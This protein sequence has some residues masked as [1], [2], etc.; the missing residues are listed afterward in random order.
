M[1]D[2]T[3]VKDIG[4]FRWGEV[5]QPLPWPLILLNRKTNSEDSPCSVLIL[6]A[7][8]SGNTGFLRL[9]G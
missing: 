9:S 7:V 8:L 1:L 2:N 5:V 4:A 6:V 3:H